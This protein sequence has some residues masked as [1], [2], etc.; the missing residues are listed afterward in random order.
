MR[1]AA[2]PARPTELFTV[3]RVPPSV[4]DYD[5]T[6]KFRISVELPRL[7]LGRASRRGALISV[8][9]S[10][11]TECRHTD[12]WR[13]P[14][15]CRRDQLTHQAGSAQQATGGCSHGTGN[16]S[17]LAA[18]FN[19]E[20]MRLSSSIVHP[21]LIQ[22]ANH[23]RDPLRGTFGLGTFFPSSTLTIHLTASCIHLQIA[24]ARAARAPLSRPPP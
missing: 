13:C 7:C 1:A 14:R 12:T 2:C 22:S 23:P 15:T 3:R 19:G 8:A 10:L 5:P 4:L 11:W 17:Y 20:R 24:R 18:L 21:L 16:Q 9:P 6:E